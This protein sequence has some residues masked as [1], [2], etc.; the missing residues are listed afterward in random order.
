MKRGNE[1]RALNDEAIFFCF[2]LSCSASVALQD[3]P[4]R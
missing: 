1:P 2:H 4:G 3:Q